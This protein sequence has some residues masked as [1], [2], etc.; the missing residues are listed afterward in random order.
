MK[1]CA[2]AFPWGIR[3]HRVDDRL[4][5]S[6][7]F[8]YVDTTSKCAERYGSFAASNDSLQALRTLLPDN[9]IVAALD[10]IDRGKGENPTLMFASGCVDSLVVKHVAGWGREFYEV[11]G[12]K[13]KYCVEV[14]LPGPL[15]VYCGC[16]AFTYA[17]LVSDNQLM[18]RSI[19][20]LSS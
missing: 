20:C 4:H 16:P 14:D 2:Y 19:A 13:E 7:G 10:L 11:S 1:A 9:L 15:P 17:V 3:T 6:R 18:V 12:S 8:P 5:K